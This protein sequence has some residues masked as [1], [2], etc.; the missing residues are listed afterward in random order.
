MIERDIKTLNHDEKYRHR[1]EKSVPVLNK[2]KDYLESNQH[3]VP[4]D[5]LT[6]KAMTYLS[7]FQGGNPAFFYA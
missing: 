7:L 5:S 3:K 6:G 1:Q 4:K 2:L